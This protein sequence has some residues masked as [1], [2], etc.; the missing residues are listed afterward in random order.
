MKLTLCIGSNEIR[1]EIH[2]A[3]DF[4]R[5]WIFKRQVESK[6][7]VI[8]LMRTMTVTQLELNM[9]LLNNWHFLVKASKNKWKR[10]YKS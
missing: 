3:E 8:W 4:L 6:I 9:D 10:R 5:T 2:V 1:N 7:Y